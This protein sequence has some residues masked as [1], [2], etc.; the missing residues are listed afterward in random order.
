MS[1]EAPTPGGRADHPVPAQPEE[2]FVV[3]D[4]REMYRIGD[5]DRMPPFLMSIVSDSDV[6]MYV[7]SR[8]GLTA[9]R[10]D[11]DH[12]LFPYETD[13][14]LHQ[15]YGV[16]GPVTL[17]RVRRDDGA[18]DL[19]EPFSD[20]AKPPGAHRNL[21]KSV[22]GNSVV[23]EE[24]HPALGLTFRYRWTASETFGCVRSS[25]LARH[26]GM[27]PARVE[28]LD[29]LLNILPSGV[30]WFTTQ[31]FS[32]LLNAYTRCEVDE[33]TGLGV[34]AMTSLLSD[35]AEPAEALRAA[36][37]WS[38]GLEQ[39][40]VAL[41]ADQVPTF[42]QGGPVRGQTVLKGRRGAYLLASELV[43]SGGESRTWHIAADVH[44][45]QVDVQR[46][47]TMLRD[48]PGSQ[49]ELLASI[50]AGEAN[51]LRNVAS[52]DGLQATADRKAAAHHLANVLFNNMRGGV[53][54]RNYDVPADDFAA[55]VR[56][57]NHGAWRDHEDYLC[58]LTGDLNTGALL[59][60]LDRRGDPDLLRLGYEYLPLTFSRRHGDPSRPWNRFAIHL[61]NPDGSR[62][63]SY[64]GNWRD[65]FQNWEALCLSFPGFLESAIAKF[66]SASTVDGF[67]PYRIGRSGIDW[68]V[69]APNEP[70]ANLGYWGD[71]QIIYLLKFL[72]ASRRFHP[73]VLER[74]L[75]RPLFA[76]ADVPYRLKPYEAILQDNRDTILF[77]S[78]AARTIA[79]RVE[80]MGADGKLVPAPD[81][82][83]YHACLAEKLLVPV[84]AKL[85]NLVVDG[86]I[87]MNTQRPE[88]NDGNNALVGSGLSMV[89]LCYL[90]RHLAFCIDLLAAAPC[91]EVQVSCEVLD[92]SEQVR[93]ILLEHRH[94]LS[95]PAIGDEDRKALLD[96]LGRAFSDYRRKVYSHGFSSKRSCPLDGLTELFRTALEYLDHGIRANRRQD[97]LYHAYNLL[98]LS[99]D[100]RKA[101]IGR[102]HEMLEGQVAA[103]SSGLLSPEEAVEL[104]ASLRSSRMYRADQDTFMLYGDR[105]LPG[106]LQKN[107]IPAAEVE[108][109]PLLAQL[110]QAG[111]TT[112]LARD[113][114]GCCRFNSDFRNARDLRCALALLEKD[115]RWRDLVRASGQ[116]VLETFERAFN[117][118]AFTG[119]S[120]AMYGYEG[121]GCIYWHMVAKLL[122]AVQECFLRAVRERRPAPVVRALAEAYYQVR[123]GLGFNKTAEAFGAFPTDPYSHTPAHAGAQQPGMTGQVKE[124]IIT[125]LGELG[126]MVEDGE[127]AFDP[128]LLRRREFFD[129]GCQ[130]T[131]VDPGGDLRRIALGPGSLAFTFCQTPIVY[132]QAPGER[133]VSVTLADGAE[134]ARAGNR[135]DRRTSELLFN[136]TGRIR[137]VLVRFPP[138]TMILD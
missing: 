33:K 40:S 93:S 130:W 57:R 16:T 70:W 129:H 69:P 9:G 106:F 112:I 15:C 67:N 65:I 82:R 136:R 109:N 98:D 118:R 79:R 116:A 36:V 131:C 41:S 101:S 102:L 58:S 89:T 7:S 30:E 122:V 13:D 32:N 110:V 51:L 31:R 133:S 34:F 4:G 38:V 132:V 120:G 128:V 53:F 21:Y 124:E 86:G 137:Q 77:D 54:A 37:A 105:E 8:G 47:S 27:S 39:C 135:L 22:L 2:G 45:G 42:R 119:R 63:L 48:R 72:E 5:F 76:Y 71:H 61:K 125:R 83:V 73:G 84:L 126:V 66:L 85:S 88:W 80:S 11:E 35:R 75:D 62:V 55:F 46:L 92:W 60:E 99:A 127:L 50:E 56:E 74:M 113:V 100:G 12:C 91:R 111:D 68:E 10:V 107:R 17:V 49:R 97:G 1:G 23:F 26:D 44:L 78:E 18:V 19:W 20:R 6:W 14:K 114:E 123:A 28:L 25:T 64:Q 96:A 121:L 81:G 103:L 115:P 24:V 134:D 59:D 104:L 138:S 43:L 52:A 95:A 87:W 3:P 94:L 29:G 90:R 108:R 117:H